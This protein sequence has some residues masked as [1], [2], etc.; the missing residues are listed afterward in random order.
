MAFAIPNTADAA[1]AD[2][3]Q[4]DK[5][6]FDILAAANNGTG[7]ATGCA[8]T[9]SNTNNG[10]LV[11]ASGVV[12]IGLQPLSRKITV[13][14]NTVAI[15]ANSSGN[16]RYDLVYVGLNGTA[17]VAQGTAAASPVFPAIPA[18]SAVL[19][20]YRVPN[21]HTVT[22]TISTNSTS[23]TD[24]RVFVPE[25]PWQEG[26]LWSAGADYAYTQQDWTKAFTEWKC[27]DYPG[28]PMAFNNVV[29]QVVDYLDAPILWLGGVGGLGL[30]DDIYTAYSVFGPYP[31]M[32]DIYGYQKQGRQ[33]SFAFPGPPGN[34]NT[35]DDSV[36]EV[37]NQTRAATVGSWAAVAGC[38][39]SALYLW[40][41]VPG[42][43]SPT[44]YRGGMRITCTSG[45]AT[46]WIAQP[47]TTL[48]RTGLVAGDIISCVAMVRSNSS[49]ASRNFNV[50]LSW[51]NAAGTQVGTDVNGG[52]V[53]VPTQSTTT[54][55]AVKL[56]NQIVP[57]TA[58]RYEMH[59]LGA[60]LALNETFDICGTA[61][62]RGQQTAV[63]GPP[64][65][66]YNSTGQ[67]GASSAQAG[68]KWFRTDTPSVPGQREYMCT[69]GGAPNDQYWAPLDAST[70][71][72]LA[73][74]TATN[75][76]VTPTSISQLAVPVLANV[77]YTLDFSMIFSSAATTTG[78]AWTFTGPATPTQLVIV[79]ECMITATSWETKHAVAYGALIHTGVGAVGTNYLCRIRLQLVNGANAGTV[80]IQFASEVAASGVT[81]KRGSMVTIS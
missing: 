78:I 18:N 17:A 22:T 50:R 68:D 39:L 48:A 2:Q 46:A 75:T 73:N 58:T 11:V 6:D 53:A 79:S 69:V 16:P 5:V 59:I 37:Y 43:E 71:L 36:H 33:W 56:E 32:A 65:V 49:A 47:G 27:R 8:V 20:A 57:A 45:G 19:A 40:A 15:A 52:T 30:N 67:R 29:W 44:G 70:V 41:T 24:K 28:A 9:G 23:I 21:G 1:F 3:A 12:K 13:A 74:D 77:Q 42:A 63:F 64:F 34:L 31:F 76:T 66:A 62:L 51:F 60:A 10:S 25:S 14:G 7:A 61:V 54:F 38:T 80:Q 26:A 55:T 35:W 72:K 81:V 4:P